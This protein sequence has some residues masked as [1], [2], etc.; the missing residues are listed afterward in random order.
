MI[1]TCENKSHEV[2]LQHVLKM[3]VDFNGL[4]LKEL[5]GHEF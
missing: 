1:E 5:D 4:E 2:K 3:I